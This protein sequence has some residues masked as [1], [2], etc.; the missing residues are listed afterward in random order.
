MTMLTLLIA[1]GLPLG[2][3][4][5]QADVPDIQGFVRDFNA[6]K[7]VTRVLAILSPT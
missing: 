1:A 2:S 4:L 3:S 5:G 7:G 6:A